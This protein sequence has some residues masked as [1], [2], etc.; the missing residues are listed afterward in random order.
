MST[1]MTALNSPSIRH[2]EFIKLTLPD[3]VVTFCSSANPITINGIEF[4][5]MG[6]L[7]QLGD[8]QRDI[9]ST[10]D[11]L[12]LSITGIDPNYVQII[13]SNDI[14]GSLVEVWRGFL[15]SDNQI[16]ETPTQQFFKRYQGIVNNVAINE[17]FREK[18]R[19]RVATCVISCA[20]FRTILENRMAGTI[21]NPVNWK[22]NYPNDTSMDRVPSIVSI[23]FD[24]GKKPKKGSRST[25]ATSTPSIDSTQGE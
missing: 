8:V 25:E 14:K 3:E 17:D 19:T 20:S 12:V 2:A 24:F 18:E 22:T 1:T 23:Y 6:G 5:G 10:S 11:D 9:K 4:I 7:L 15:D 13:L 16:I 21:T